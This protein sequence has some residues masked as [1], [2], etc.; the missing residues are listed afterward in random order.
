MP[1]ARDRV[2]VMRERWLE[3]AIALLL[4]ILVCLTGAGLVENARSECVY[5]QNGTAATCRSWVVP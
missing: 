1:G 2:V 5:G 3:L 4:F